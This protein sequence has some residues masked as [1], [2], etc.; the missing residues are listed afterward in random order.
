MRKQRW[1]N[2]PFRIIISEEGVE[3][4]EAQS[5]IIKRRMDLMKKLEMIDR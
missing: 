3:I 4:N 1:E 5:L 2:N